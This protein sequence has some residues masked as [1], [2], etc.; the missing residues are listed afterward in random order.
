MHPSDFELI[1]Y[2]GAAPVER[3]R[4]R[5]LAEHL[6]V[7]KSCRER[8]ARLQ[9]WRDTAVDSL[10]QDLPEAARSLGER[11]YQ[12]AL[13]ARRIIPLVPMPFDV[14]E[15]PARLAADGGAAVEP[16]LG[17]RHLATLYSENPEMVLRVMRNPRTQE[18]SLH[19]LG[20]NPALTRNVLIHIVDPPMDFVTD[21]R[22][23][24]NIGRGRLTDPPTLQWQI[25]LPDAIFVLR[26]LEHE[27]SSGGTDE[28]ELAADGDNRL[29]VTLERAPEGMVLH[30]RPIAIGGRENPERVRLVISQGSTERRIVETRGAEPCMVGRLSA[31]A[32]IDIRI[33]AF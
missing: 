1:T 20:K 2:G 11:V 5:V 31:A 17:L 10:S 14:A 26:P 4:M 28:F 23:V 25:H 15:E 12:D 13:F 16:P 33:F 22:G 7:C 18:D 29:G 8:L 24:A 32:P 19:L 21:Q 6:Q 27:S 3:G 9:A 30:L